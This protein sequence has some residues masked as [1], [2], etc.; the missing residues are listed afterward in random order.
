MG[1]KIK[2]CATLSFIFPT[3]GKKKEEAFWLQNKLVLRPFAPV[4]KRSELKG[5]RLLRL[6][7]VSVSVCLLLTEKF[8]SY[9]ICN[10]CVIGAPFLGYTEKLIHKDQSDYAKLIWTVQG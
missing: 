7:R 8:I 9:Q 5:R 6:L 1:R 10:M 2:L 4:N 3:Q